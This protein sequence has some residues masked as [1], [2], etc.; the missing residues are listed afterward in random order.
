MQPR[1]V[2]IA[3]DHPMI[4]KAL[5]NLLKSEWPTIQVFEASNGFE[6]IE[7]YED[8]AP[9]ILL[10][11]FRMP[12]LNGYE[13]AERLLR[14]NKEARII[15]FTMFDSTAIILN[16]LKIGGLGF[17]I[18]ESNQEDI[19][20]AVSAVSM[21][22]YYF[23]S[24]H[25]QEILQCIKKG[26]EQKLPKLKF[27]H[28]ELQLIMKLSKGLTSKEIGEEMKLSARTVESYRYNLI[29]KAQVKNSIELIKFMYQNGVMV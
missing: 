21:G 3:D 18:K 7:L 6:T 12:K 8:H 28:Q 23:N 26:L 14:R 15:L 11:D 17:L 1:K 25:E 24:S 19:L 16:F 13:A 5:S 10:I 29:E 27:S 2:L 22:D 4:R 20:K 9:N